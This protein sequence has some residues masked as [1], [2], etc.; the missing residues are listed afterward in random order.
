M[1]RLL[2]L[3][4]MAFGNIVSGQEYLDFEDLVLDTTYNNG[5]TFSTTGTT[6]QVGPFQSG[7]GTTVTDGF[8]RVRDFQSA[9][10]NGQ[11]LVF[12]NATIQLSFPCTESVSY[13]FGSFGGNLNLSVNGDF[14]IVSSPSD[15][16]GL[17]VGGVNVSTMQTG[18]NTGIVTLTGNVTTL[19][20]GG[21]EFALDHLCYTLCPDTDPGDRRYI[22]FSEP[23]VP[24]GDLTV[25]DE[26][27]E[28]FVSIQVTPFAFANGSTTDQ[29]FARESVG[30]AGHTGPEVTTNNA[31][32]RFLFYECVGRVEVH[33]G[34]YG[35]NVNLSVNGDMANLG[36]LLDADG[37]T[38]GR[39]QVSVQKS[40][41][42]EGGYLGILTLEGE[43]KEFE[44]GG[45]EFAMDHICYEPCA[46]MSC[47]DFEEL[48]VRVPYGEGE[49]FSEDGVIMTVG[50]FNN[51]S[52]GFV[53]ADDNLRANH[54]GN[55]LLLN[56]AKLDFLIDCATHLSLYYGHFGGDIHLE[57]NGE[58]ISHTGP[59]SNLSG[60]T[61]GGVLV[62]I[63]HMSVNGGEQG[64]LVLEGTIQSI[65]IGGQELWIDHVCFTPCQPLPDCIDFE[66]LP[67]TKEYAVNEAFSEDGIT[68]TVE[69]FLFSN[70]TTTSAGMA[71]VDDANKAGHLGNDL[72]LV[73]ANLR[74]GVDCAERIRLHFGDYGGIVNL[75]LN[76]TPLI[77]DDLSDFD[78][79]T[80]G[81]LTIS[82][83]QGT[84]AGGVI[85]VL[86]I[87]GG[88]ITEFGIG[89][90]EFW[91]DHLCYMPC[92]P[93]IVERCLEMDSMED[94]PDNV[95]TRVHFSIIV[96]GTVE[97]TLLT[98]STL[99]A[100][101]W[102]DAGA[103]ITR[104]S[105]NLYR[106]YVDIPKTTVRRFYQ[107]DLHPGPAAAP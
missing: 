84:V 40:G 12:N 54:A 27:Q 65:S 91:I 63:R 81:S 82:V 33:F 50:K 10:H 107:I 14:R 4:S 35:G 45:Q 58:P 30:T 23:P 48:T 102:G 60:S 76:G 42:V 75:L 69:R 106:L 47:I 92:D 64:V 57:V 3:L 55:D 44:L 8:V 68:M 99:G 103:T 19:A 11:D 89:G 73:N 43:I 5:D 49:G 62:T 80:V 32:L 52:G 74:V 87:W 90:Q 70:G 20:I 101:S 51:A 67:V 96:R 78:G 100:L 17:L 61:I 6:V 29:G 53:A 46:G 24:D 85:G 93:V 31:N 38:L 15:L 26:W 88:P 71:V 83:T 79:M 28:D 36:N 105:G 25:G 56:D 1:K 9:G 77:G 86:E 66:A 104:H 59:L 7:N 16:D 95:T 72:A 22:D 97:L 2:L 94:L 18:A 21:S 13:H 98:S 34:A 39:A 37:L 41:E